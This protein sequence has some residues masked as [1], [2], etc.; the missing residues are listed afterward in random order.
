VRLHSDRPNASNVVPDQ[1]NENDLT[2][3]YRRD[4]T[5]HVG[6][7]PRRVIEQM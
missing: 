3:T 4:E 1:I 2:W 7:V 5:T 6:H